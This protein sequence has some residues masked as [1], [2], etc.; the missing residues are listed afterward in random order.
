MHLYCITR[1]IKQDVDRF[2]S[3]LE[4]QYFPYNVRLPGSDEIQK[5]AVQLSMRPIQLWE[6]VF[7]K[8]HL[9]EVRT[10]MKG[11]ESIERLNRPIE[12]AMLRKA[13]GAKKLPKTYTPVPGRI[14]HKQNVEI[15]EIGY[16]ED[17][18]KDGV[19]RL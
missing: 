1:G 17:E 7:P 4:A 16:K 2:I 11:V 8:E 3:N 14:I 5:A 13:V 19:E 10:L 18:I 6:I 9:D 15:K 12:E